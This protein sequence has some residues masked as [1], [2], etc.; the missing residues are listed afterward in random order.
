MG[1]PPTG[2]D[3]AKEVDA[4]PEAKKRLI[5]I[6]ATIAGEC[7][8][9]EA[10]KELEINR[11]RLHQ[12]RTRMLQE[13]AEGLEVRSP[14]RKPTPRD[15]KDEEIARLRSELEHQRQLM[16]TLD[17]RTELAL[18]GIGPHGPLGSKKRSRSR[19]A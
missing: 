17:L 1:R 13:A 12:L 2:S 11:S 4:S 7:T 14:G 8:I 6:V 19:K 3:L 9:E 5:W 15:P 18:A 10:A 16:K